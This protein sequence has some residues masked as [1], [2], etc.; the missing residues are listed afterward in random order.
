M[1]LK[2]K[3]ALKMISSL[4]CVLS[5]H[6]NVCVS[7]DG[8]QINVIHHKFTTYLIFEA[9]QVLFPTASLIFTAVMFHQ[10]IRERM[11]HKDLY[12]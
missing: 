11:K 7:L 1:S 6:P 4:C 5:Q 3:E 8:M 2:Q 9:F 10:V 12:P